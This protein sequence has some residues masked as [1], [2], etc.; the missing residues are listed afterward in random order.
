VRATVIGGPLAHSVLLGGFEKR[1]DFLVIVFNR[2]TLPN[3]KTYSLE[4]VALDPEE[5]RLS[6]RSDVDRHTFERWALFLAGTWLGAA[7]DIYAQSGTTQTTTTVPGGT[8]TTISYPEF[9]S[10]RVNRIAVGALG[11]ATADQ[12]QGSL[13]IPS[14][15]TLQAN[16]QIGVMI[17]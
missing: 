14:T 9:D 12:L 2:I 6:V 8:S 5:S 3:K 11:Q 4:A 10:D 1:G 15:V 17:L 7:G 16:T 13:A